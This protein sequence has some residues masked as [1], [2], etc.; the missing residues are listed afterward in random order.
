MGG[1]IVDRLKNHT[2][3]CGR[4]VCSKCS[5]IDTSIYRIS[6]LQEGPAEKWERWIKGVIQIDSGFETYCPYVFLTADISRTRS[7]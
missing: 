5:G 6:D 2:N 1:N 3:Q 4:F 7:R